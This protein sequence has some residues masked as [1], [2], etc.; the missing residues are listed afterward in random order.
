MPS[1]YRNALLALVPSLRAFAFCLSQ[2]R[3]EADDLAYGSLIEIWSKHRHK[4]RA[5]LRVAAFS[6]VSAQYRRSNAAHPSPDHTARESRA[7]TQERF[8]AVL[9][10][11]W[12][13]EREALALVLVWGFTDE[14]AAQ[15]CNVDVAT[16]GS[17]IASAYLS[18]VQGV[19]PRIHAVSSDRVNIRRK[20]TKERCHG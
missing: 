6:V 10:S 2:D 15:I 17:R 3:A 19:P 12:W 8:F 20:P 13:G 4:T 14:Q 16:F 7:A 9:E 11:L 1:E 5:E 18:L